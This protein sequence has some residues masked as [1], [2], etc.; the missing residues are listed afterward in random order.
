VGIS[1]KGGTG[2]PDLA[3]TEYR[4][5]TALVGLGGL[6]DITSFVEPYKDVLNNTMMGYCT[7][8]D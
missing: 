4:S 6:M 1:I 2:V 5:I 8:Y 7:L 3:V